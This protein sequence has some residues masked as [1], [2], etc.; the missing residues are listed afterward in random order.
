MEWLS[1]GPDPRLKGWET[2]VGGPPHEGQS[3]AAAKYLRW[4]S[5]KILGEPSPTPTHPAELLRAQ[6]MVGIYRPQT[7][8]EHALCWDPLHGLAD[9]DEGA[10]R[11]ESR[12][13]APA[14]LGRRL[15]DLPYL[16]ESTS[17]LRHR[18]KCMP[19]LE[20][21]VGIRHLSAREIDS[22]GMAADPIIPDGAVVEVRGA[23]SRRPPGR[24]RA[25]IEAALLEPCAESIGML[26][27]PRGNAVFLRLGVVRCLVSAGCIRPD[28]NYAALVRAVRRA[29]LSVLDIEPSDWLEVL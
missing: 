27:W 11:T 18:G 29:G 21:L 14:A 28:A 22:W 15:G 1:N 10:M 5:G 9:A 2:R 19:T 7:P 3:Q 26:H 25:L 20:T 17:H 8:E 13:H 23:T 24:S 6:G 4:L 12:P 16:L